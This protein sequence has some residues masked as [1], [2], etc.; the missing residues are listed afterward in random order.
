MVI[1]VV[2]INTLI[3]LILLCVAWRVWQ[4]KQEIGKIAD[5]FTHYE[6]CSH[7]VLYTAPEKISAAQQNI[8][9]LRQGN[10]RLEAQ[11]QQVRQIVS[12]LFLGRQVWRH[13]FPR[14]GSTNG[15]KTITKLE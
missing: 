15:K 13:S 5:R 10:Q 11:I 3:S 6:R 12:L 14:L 8:Y 2:V 7:A 9:H 4:L 1:L